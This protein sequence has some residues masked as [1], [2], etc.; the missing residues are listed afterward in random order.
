M[1]N[2]EKELPCICWLGVECV[3]LLL[4]SEDFLNAQ[5]RILISPSFRY[6]FIHSKSLFR[7]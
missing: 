2:M 7:L 4:F 6:H 3:K 1:D 5:A